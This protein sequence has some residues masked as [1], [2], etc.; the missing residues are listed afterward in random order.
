M[1]Y[2]LLCPQAD[3]PVPIPCAK[4]SL[5]LGQYQARLIRST[6][7]AV[8]TK[9][10]ADL[11]MHWTMSSMLANKHSSSQYRLQPAIAEVGIMQWFDGAMKPWCVLVQWCRGIDNHGDYEVVQAL[12]ERVDTVVKEDVLLLKVDVE[13]LE[14]AVMHSA[15]RLLDRYT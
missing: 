1:L 15:T 4:C 10:S 8:L 6:S 9:Q 7:N 13:G 3:R 2:V 5:T 14:P 12:G 11:S